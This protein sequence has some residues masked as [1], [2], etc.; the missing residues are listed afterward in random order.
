[1]NRHGFE[2]VV[3]DLDGTLIDTLPD[4]L[5]ALNRLMG[6]EGR[7]EIAYE[8]GRYMVGHGTRVMLER[9]FAATGPTQTAEIL[10]SLNRRFV[11]YYLAAPAVMSAPYD[12]VE[13]TL[14]ALAADGVILG[15]CTNKPHE[16]SLRIL[17]ELGLDRHFAAAIGGDALDVHKPDAAHL[18][19][20]IARMGAVPGKAVMVG[21]SEIDVRTARNADVPVVVVE[22]GYTAKP[23]HTLGADA[24]IAGF[25][26][27]SAALQR[28]ADRS[29]E[30]EKAR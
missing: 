3:F 9:A 7:R 18:L 8:E 21:D 22:Y 25:D 20:T 1:M 19:T 28:I 27:L 2:A 15:V 29:S 6:E 14:A 13:E 17:G 4:I 5:A 12:G 11:D 30:T 16:I 10:D 24:V 23:P 26:G